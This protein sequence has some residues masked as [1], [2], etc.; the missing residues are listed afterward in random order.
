MKHFPD[1]TSFFTFCGFLSPAKDMY[2]STESCAPI[3]LN[4][5]DTVYIVCVQNAS[6]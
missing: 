4:S 6:K 1:E 5:Q 2:C 3:P